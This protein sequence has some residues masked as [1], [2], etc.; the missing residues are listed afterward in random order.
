M[1][2][3][4]EERRGLGG[5]FA[6]AYVSGVALYVLGRWVRVASAVGEQHHPAEYWTRVFH[7]AST[8][9]VVI[10]FGYMLKG[11]VLPGLKA[12]R[13]MPSGIGLLGALT[14]LIATAICIL[15]AGENRWA[16]LLVQVHVVL[17]LVMPGMIFLHAAKRLGAKNE[18]RPK[19]RSVAVRTAGS[20][21]DGVALHG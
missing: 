10:A 7:S 18:K 9:I 21:L 15:Y 12:K 8:Y 2:L 3:R 5:T 14:A 19:E 13:K 16:P 20:R 6:L 17:G 4:G 1:K 11:H